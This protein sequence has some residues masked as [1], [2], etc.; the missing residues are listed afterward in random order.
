MVVSEEE[1]KVDEEWVRSEYADVDIQ[2]II[3]MHQTDKWTDVPRDVEVRIAKHKIV[4]V[5]YVPP[6]VRHMIDYEA[7]KKVINE[8]DVTNA[9]RRKKLGFADLPAEQIEKLSLLEQTIPRRRTAQQ[10]A[11]P[12]PSKVARNPMNVKKYEKIR[13][14][15]EEEKWQKSVIR[16]PVTTNEKW[17]GRM[18]NNK[19]T[20]LEEEF[21]TMAFGEPFVK[22]LKMG[23]LRGF[24]DV[25]VGDYKPSHLHHHPNLQCHGAP[26]VHFNQTDGKDLC[27]SKALASALFSLGFREEASNIDDFGEEILRGA[28]VDALENVVKHARSILPTWIV[29][30]RLPRQFDWRVDLDARNLLLG[31]LTASDGSCCHAVCI[32]GGFVYDANEVKALPLCE[33]A[34]NYCTSTPLV[35]SEFVGFRRGYIFRYEGQRQQRIDKMTLKTEMN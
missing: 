14:E 16:K 5:R 30:R 8:K 26:A 33:E 29:I 3:N 6:Q 34:L 19:E 12:T 17:L 13:L 11:P 23:E 9:K 18:E 2:H 4:R 1:L 25:P 24:V 21:V 35:K 27:V 22:E 28:V 10:R 20:T 7:T 32:H 15:K 31:V